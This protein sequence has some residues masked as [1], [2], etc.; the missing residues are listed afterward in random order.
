[1]SRDFR[2]SPTGQNCV[3]SLISRLVPPLVM[4]LS[5]FIL[6]G[7]A[8]GKGGDMVL[9]PSIDVRSGDQF[10]KAMA[11]DSG[12]NT[13]VV[14]YTNT[15]AGNDYQVAKFK[16]DGTG[17]AWLPAVFGGSGN[18]TATAVAVD[19]YN[20]I[21]V[22]GYS[23][24]GSNYDIRTIKY[25]GA[26][27][28]VV[29][30]QIFDDGAA[31]GDDWATSIA[32]DSAA[33]VYVAGYSF[34]GIKLDD[35]LLIKY[36]AAG[37]APEWVDLSD[38]ISYQNNHNRFTAVTTGEGGIAVTGYS[39]KGGLDFDIITRKY[40][41][42][43]TLIREW[44]YSS[45]GGRD[46]RG[47]AVKMDSAGYVAIS[48]YLT[49][50]SNN[51]DIYTAKYYP[52]SDTPV[53]EKIF[54]NDGGSGNDEPGGFWVDGLGDVYVSGSTGTLAG[55]TDFYTV[56]YSGSTGE[57]IWESLFNAGD[58]SADIPVG[59]I[60]DDALDGGVFV[61]GYTNVSSTE[62]F[63][64]LKYRKDN[65][66]LLWHA[67]WNGSANRNDRPAGIG[68]SF[69][70]PAVAGWSGAGTADNDFTLLMYDFGSLNAPT[71]LTATAASN[72]SILL[73]WY[74][75]SINEGRFVIQRKLGETGTWADITTITSPAVPNSM[76]TGSSTMISYTDGTP[77]LVSNKY[78]YYRVKAA[79]GD[80]D[81]HYSNETHALTKV[82]MYEQP[83][84]SFKYD[85][86]DH[87][88]DIATD[89]TFGSDNHPVVTGYSDLTEEG[90]EPGP[91]THTFDYMTFKLDKGTKA[92]KWK[93]LYDSGDG[94]TDMAA[95]VALDSGGNLLVTGTA[96]LSGGSD[97]SDEL[98]TRKVQTSTVTDPNTVPDFLWEDQFGTQVGIDYATAIS[99]VRDGSD[100]SVV[101]GYGQNSDVPQDHDIFVIKLNNNGA[102]AWTPIV[103]DSGRNDEPSGLAI[104]SA[105][106]IFVTGYSYD[107][108]VNPEGSYDWFTAKYSGSTGNLI[109][110]DTYDISQNAYAV[111]GGN[112][113]ALSIDVDAAGSAYVTGY[114][115]NSDGTTV[116]Y[117]VK[118]DGRAEPAGDRRIW[119]KSF[120]YPGFHAEGNAVKVDPIDG[121][122]VVAGSA[123]VNGTD[124]DFHLIRY[125]PVDGSLTEGGLKPFWEIN[126]DR[127]G[128]YEYVTAM[129]MDSS[130][131]IYVTGNT[132]SGPDTDPLSDGTSNI[133]SLIYDYEGTFLGALDYDGAG[134]RDEANAIT[135]NYVGEAFVAG[136]TTNAAGNPD[137]VVLKQANG[138]L[139]VPAP[140]TVTPQPDA[141]K[142]TLNWQ[143]NST[144]AT[145]II[146]RTPG[147]ATEQSSWSGIATP[148]VGST[149]YTDAGREPGKNYCYRINAIAG[150][151]PSRK[152]VR[153]V[154][155]RLTPPALATPIVDPDLTSLKVTL[156]W[157][158]VANNTGYKIERKAGPSGT[159]IELATKPANV[160]T[161]ED[162]SGLVRGTVYYYRVSTNSQSGYSLP[163]NEGTAITAPLLNNPTSI[164]N[165][166]MAFSWTAVTGATSYILEAKLAEGN[167]SPVAGC[168]SITATTCTGTGL[169]PLGHYTFHLKAVN[170]AA[171]SPWSNEI[172]AQA[173][174]GV[175]PLN[176]PTNSTDVQV[177]LS[178]TTV[179]GATSY[180]VEA[181]PQ[182][183]V[184]GPA[185]VA[186]TGATGTSCIA[187][188]L[189]PNVTY[190]FH[191]KASNTS[192]SSDWSPEKSALTKLST[193]A[194]TSAAGTSRAQI[195]LVWTPITG[196][197]AY[198]VEYA[199]CY[200]SNL[201]SSCRGADG[202]YNGWVTLQSGVTNPFYSAINLAAG[203]NYRFKVTATVTGNSS[204]PSGV[205]NAWTHLTPPAVTVTPVD[206][207]SLTL[208]WSD[209]PGET[210]YAVERDAAMVVEGLA[211]NT[212]SYPNINLAQQTEYCY[213]VKA[214][215]TEPVPPPPAWS[216]PVCR[217]TPLPAPVQAAPSI[218]D[219]THVK[220]DWNQV[221]NNSGYEVERC[222]TTDNNQPITHPIGVCTNLSPKLGTDI[223]TFTDTVAA[224]STN[225]YRI[226]A[227]YNGSLDWTAFSNEY[228]VTA[229]PPTPGLYPPAA[230]SPTQLN[231]SWAN[232][233]GDN[234]YSLYW[235]ER[236]GASCTDDNWNGPIAQGLNVAAYNHTDRTIGT[237]Y[238]Y[239]IKAN[240]PPGP[241]ATPDSAYSAIVTQTTLTAAPVLNP[242]TGIT[243]SALCLAWSNATPNTGYK[244]ERKT[245][246]TGTWGQVA[247]PPANNTD[248]AIT[249]CDSNLLPGTVYYYR[250]STR[251]AG[252]YSPT[253]NE[254][255]AITTPSIP[256]ITATAVSE[257]RI[258]VCWPVVYGATNYKVHRKTGSDGTYEPVGNPTVGYSV[259]YCGHP[260]PSV[261]CLTAAAITYCYQDVGLTEDT[262]YF[263]HVHSD[264]GTESGGSVEK[265]A[266]TLNIPNQN[267]TAIALNG[268]LMVKLDWTPVAC[269][270]VPCDDPDNFEIQRQVRD[271]YWVQVTVVDGTTTSYTDNLAIDPQVKYRYRVRSIKGSLLSP[272]SE[273]AVFAKPYVSGTNVCR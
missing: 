94:G 49:N 1:M 170:A 79:N 74:D 16:A 197:T 84:W 45:P 27:G 174:L 111:A 209:G 68:L 230:A 253:S 160:V 172:T 124:S 254:Q 22:T 58:G 11:V 95:G 249:W 72:T 211:I 237:F 161:H 99:M 168:T 251:N 56:R 77:P 126:F 115:T 235:K 241:P 63:I 258:D 80:G 158:L 169:T 238:C 155:T 153:C 246:A 120:N 25:N 19:K 4:L 66:S 244:V 190:Y 140:V 212:T 106:D 67:I 146:E 205:V 186:C 26:T 62:D 215:S 226:R 17:P 127:P 206:L 262:T 96:Y 196:A 151:L 40:G 260:Y 87:L 29:W 200:N 225:R 139:L 21:L 265:S 182:G 193:P 266:K 179:Y 245:G 133:L 12:G 76:T 217:T 208:T 271:G 81:S 269:S 178:W 38:D 8:F 37:G 23:W 154:T 117:T 61:G 55:N 83:S 159:W 187:T 207:T 264:N 51:K 113:Q 145:Y 31:N 223:N 263:Y 65:G 252:G 48:G 122:A 32:V 108:T 85:G 98:Y 100:N 250:V 173:I 233:A 166:K 231:V 103:Y 257:D 41:F 88:E 247:L 13:I 5:V 28:A 43:K 30:E 214:Y 36:P 121:A 78:Y 107:K 185:G 163:S 123:Y 91:D 162:T 14:G 268:G 9:L 236:A 219:T 255:S 256:V 132:R 44:R 110:S 105:G 64:T 71:K 273:A 138:Y 53:W 118:Y 46:D 232:V 60:V 176:A 221:P 175:P 116:S 227:Y 102:R 272:F 129:T 261:G 125:N 89:I 157:G 216:A 93:A 240:G 191:I 101:L 267:L 144:T 119:E 228:W 204:A 136:F 180:T 86:A 150:S 3:T 141:T 234:G 149:T 54:D 164:A 202:Y 52:S 189:T 203:T 134:G 210:N 183:G 243:P 92:V 112:D 69:R 50:A 24:N 109:W 148:G 104:D 97:K 143:H 239:K 199:S 248:P 181:K 82:V 57:I 39:S 156:N 192:G 165:N 218:L 2:S 222:P 184:Y 35:F 242:L 34:N 224:G 70:N 90:L 142:A 201:P 213:R 131:Y 167:Y 42:D 130:G 147:P 229:K 270:P 188:G 128:S 20:D 152:V 114:A 171:T 59:I 220:I 177:S 135:A 198:T 73:K 33:N 18:D 6:F 194:I 47:V 195:D 7:S 15:G 75:N 259:S 137:Y 10:G